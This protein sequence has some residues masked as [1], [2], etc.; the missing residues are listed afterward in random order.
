MKALIQRF[1]VLSLCF[2]VCHDAFAFR[3]KGKVIVDADNLSKQDFSIVAELED[4]SVQKTDLN[5][6]GK[7]VLRQVTRGARLSLLYQGNFYAPVLLAVENNGRF[8]PYRKALR[9]DLCSDTISRGAYVLKRKPRWRRGAMVLQVSTEDELAYSRRRLKKKFLITDDLSSLEQDTCRPAGQGDSEGSL[10]D[11]FYD[12]ND[13]DGD[14]K[15]NDEDIDDDNDGLSD[16][17]DNDND[18]DGIFDDAD[19]DNNDQE[20]LRVWNFQQLH[21]DRED[22]YNSRV[23]TVNKNTIDSALEEYGGLAMQ[24]ID[25]ESVELD[26]GGSFDGSRTGLS[27]C[28]SG[29]PGRSKEPYPNGLALPDEM[30]SDGDGKAEISAGSTG[31]FQVA[32]GVGSDEIQPGD[33]F[34]QEVTD[35]EGKVSQ[36]IGMIN[37]VVHDVPG[38]VSIQTAFTTHTFNY[39]AN[40]NSIGSYNNPIPVPA[41]GDVEIT[42]TTYL[43]HYST[44]GDTRVVPAGLRMITNIPNGPCTGSES[45]NGCQSGSTEGPGLLPGSL[46]SNPSEGWQVVSDGVQSAALT[47][48]LEGEDETVTYTVNL[49]GEGGVTDWDLGE[50]VKV[51]IQ[52]MYNNG[53]TAAH[54]VWFVRPQ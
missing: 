39:P 41:T 19:T 40:N 24:V 44:G 3:L 22:A 35:S 21:L 30:D 14:G 20:D 18:G 54:N 12:A 4:G 45:G 46:Y 2:F 49:T 36:Y 31:D 5:A 28:S 15:S 48:A 34:V 13:V 29:G 33:T 38:I 50:Q 37:G 16:A 10:L 42:V 11:R 47:D 7:F 27:Y 26:C 25:G 23:M 6:R 52:S 32:P 17:F 9:N 1:F 51:P 8:L 43:P 53:T